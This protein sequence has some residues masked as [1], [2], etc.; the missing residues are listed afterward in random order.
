[1]VWTMLL[2]L[3]IETSAAN[4]ARCER[5]LYT[6][7][8]KNSWREY[9]QAGAKQA[10]R[11]RL[12]ETLREIQQPAHALDLGA[13]GGRDSRELLQRGWRVTAV[14]SNVTSIDLL[15]ILQEQFPGRLSLRAQA[16]EDLRLEPESFELITGSYSLPFCRPEGFGAFW[17]QLRRALKPGG[18]LSVELFGV[19]DAWNVTEPKMSFFTRAEVDQLIAGLDQ[20][21]VRE[22]EYDASTFSGEMKH[23]HVFT[24]ILRAP[25]PRHGL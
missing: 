19:R 21:V 7:P 14:D 25:A 9:N 10:A 6:Q 15:Q 2:T 5:N 4:I 22:E 8:V 16:F 18:Y 24:L 12:I 20:V 1:M 17:Q 11:P 23:W 3:S 13:G